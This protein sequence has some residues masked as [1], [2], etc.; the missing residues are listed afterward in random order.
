MN[1]LIFY[2]LRIIAALRKHRLTESAA[3]SSIG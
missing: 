2:L 3:R 1:F